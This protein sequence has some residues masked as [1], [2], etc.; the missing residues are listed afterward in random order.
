MPRPSPLYALRLVVHNDRQ[1]QTPLFLFRQHYSLFYATCSPRL[2][3]TKS[4]PNVTGRVRGFP[5]VAF[6]HDGR[7]SHSP[8]SSFKPTVH[9]I[10]TERYRRPINAPRAFNVVQL[11][12]HNVHY[13]LTRPTLNA[14]AFISG[15]Q[16]MPIASRFILIYPRGPFVID[17]HHRMLHLA[18][19]T[20]S[21]NSAG[22]SRHIFA[23]QDLFPLGF[24]RFSSSHPHA[25]RC[26]DLS[27]ASSYL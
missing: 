2:T 15:R 20:A 12:R 3:A 25:L 4:N 19:V 18:D 6:T 16:P 27:P 5:R 8:S 10:S 11:G 22:T 13:A 17:V 21:P 7:C 14:T 24:F 9:S 23:S 1:E 26:F